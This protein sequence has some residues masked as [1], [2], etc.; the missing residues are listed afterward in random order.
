MAKEAAEVKKITGAAVKIEN[1][2]RWR[3]IKPEILDVLDVDA[4][5]VGC[6]FIGVDPSRVGPVRIMSPQPF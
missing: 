5:P 1:L 2:K 4:D 3:A 6:V